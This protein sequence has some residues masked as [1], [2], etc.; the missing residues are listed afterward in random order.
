MLQPVYTKQFERDV[1]L[2]RHRGKKLEKL[3]LVIQVLVEEKPLGPIH[4]DHNL[5]GKW[6]KRREC[7]IESDW[8]LIYKKDTAQI[9]FER[10]GTHADLFKR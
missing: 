5:V 7:H 1:T 9:A 8:L 3:K 2:A 6:Q 10:T 4:H